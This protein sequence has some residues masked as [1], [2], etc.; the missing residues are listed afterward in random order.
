MDDNKMTGHIYHEPKPDPS[1]DP[2]QS[3][4]PGCSEVCEACE[5]EK[6]HRDWKRSAT[7]IGKGDK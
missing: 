6:A 5:E 1:K 2:C 3:C 4:R 7:N